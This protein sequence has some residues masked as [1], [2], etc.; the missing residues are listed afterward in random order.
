MTLSGKHGTVKRGNVK[1][2][3]GKIRGRDRKKQRKATSTRYMHS[4]SPLGEFVFPFNMLLSQVKTI[5]NFSYY[6]SRIKNL[7]ST[8]TCR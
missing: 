4:L 3:G 5:E 2:S 6:P 1:K 7:V 8:L